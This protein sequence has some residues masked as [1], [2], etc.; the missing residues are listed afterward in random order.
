MTIQLLGMMKLPKLLLTKSC[1]PFSFKA[2]D[3]FCV[4][5]TS[6]LTIMNWMEKHYA[7]KVSEEGDPMALVRVK[8]QLLLTRIEMRF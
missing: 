3:A 2:A 6:N 7:V 8:N 4:P 1:P 5:K